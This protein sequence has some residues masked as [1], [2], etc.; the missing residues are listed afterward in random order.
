MKKVWIIA[1]THF[2]HEDVPR[3]IEYAKAI[4]KQKSSLLNI[5]KDHILYHLGDISVARGEGHIQQIHEEIFMKMQCRKVLIVGNHDRKSYSWFYDHGWDFV[6]ERISIKFLSYYITFIHDPKDYVLAK[7]E[8]L[9]H[10]H[11]H[12]IY[13]PIQK[14]RI[15]L[16]PEL[17]GYSA[18]L[19]DKFLEKYKSKILL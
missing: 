3:N 2:G 14:N 15:L 18:V 6:A 12:G 4:K 7:D 17:E 16:S 11:Y 5:H 10:G 1:D 8:I 13:Q 9:I 19:L